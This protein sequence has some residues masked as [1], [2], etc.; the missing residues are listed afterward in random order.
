MKQGGKLVRDRIPEIIRRK[1][2]MLQVRKLTLSEFKQA[3]KV[4]LCE[5]AEEARVARKRSDLVE[6]LADVI[7][8]LAAIGKVYDISKG[9]LALARRKKLKERGGFA[10]RLFLKQ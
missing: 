8:V 6:E 1:G 4:K 9:D 2:E 3:L 10:N 7:E 5:E